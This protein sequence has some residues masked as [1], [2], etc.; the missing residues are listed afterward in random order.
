M[1]G[2]KLDADDLSAMLQMLA[3]IEAAELDVREAG[4]RLARVQ[5]DFD[6]W[7]LAVRAKYAIGPEDVIM[8]DGTIHRHASAENGHG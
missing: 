7:K 4:H 2:V 5:L 6:R 8:R 3:N 1:H